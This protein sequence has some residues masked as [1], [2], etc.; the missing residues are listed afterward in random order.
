[1]VTH[2]FTSGTFM[3]MF[4]S[5]SL[6]RPWPSGKVSTPEAEGSRLETRSRI[7]STKDPPYISICYTLNHKHGA[8]SPLLVWY[9]NLERGCQL[10]RHVTTVQNYEVRPK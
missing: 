1:M 2:L 4:L 6:G 10:R 3:A 5:V 9:E 7:L 8:K